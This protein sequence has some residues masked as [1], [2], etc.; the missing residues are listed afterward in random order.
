MKVIWMILLY[1][2]VHV[3]NDMQK[4]EIVSFVHDAFRSRKQPLLQEQYHPEFPENY[5][6]AG[7]RTG[8]SCLGEVDP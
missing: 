3:Y 8:V 4:E 6:D 7:S 2:D 5:N 1:P